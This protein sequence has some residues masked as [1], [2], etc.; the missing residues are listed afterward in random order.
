M[1]KYYELKILMEN[2]YLPSMILFYRKNLFKIVF[3]QNFFYFNFQPIF[4][5]FATHFRTN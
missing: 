2:N 4:K 3:G 1:I 5:M